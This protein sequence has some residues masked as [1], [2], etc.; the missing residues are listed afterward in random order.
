M[1]HGVFC[2]P[3]YRPIRVCNVLEVTKSSNLFAGNELFK[4]C[5]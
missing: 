2:Y 4:Y 3:F 5:P 1:K